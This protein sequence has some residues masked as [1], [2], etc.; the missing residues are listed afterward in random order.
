MAELKGV[1]PE[2][3]V[4][5]NNKGGKQSKTAYAFHLIDTDAILDLAEVL[6]LGAE[7]YARD[8]WRLIS[9][10]EHMN[11]M[12]IHYYAWLKGDKSDNHLGHFFTRAM[13][14]YATAKQEEREKN[15]K[16]I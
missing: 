8:N 9:S 14:V 10:E 16:Q 1:G 15:E 11:H 13:M 12:L 6:A 3:P 4:I 7:K 5:T 2:A